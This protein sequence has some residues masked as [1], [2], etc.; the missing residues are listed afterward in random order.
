MRLF[1][2]ALLLA[3]ALPLAGCAE[4][5]VASASSLITSKK[6]VPDQLISMASRK[7]C[8]VLRRRQ[9]RT[10]CRED[11]PNPAPNVYCF[12]TLGRVECYDKPVDAAGHRREVIGRNDHNYAKRW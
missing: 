5:I 4:V 11:E 7:D 3:F 1:A 10:Y 12:S 8:S 2:A 6:T 9:G